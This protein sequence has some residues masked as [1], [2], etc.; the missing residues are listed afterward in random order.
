[1]RRGRRRLPRSEIPNSPAGDAGKGRRLRPGPGK[2]AR[3]G[4]GADRPGEALSEPPQTRKFRYL[5]PLFT[6]ILVGTSYIPFPPWALYFCLVPLWVFWLGEPSRKRIFLGGWVSQFVFTLIGFHWVAHTAHEF[7]HFSWPAAALT[8]LLYCS[9]GHLFLPLSGLVWSLLRD[10]GNLPPWAQ[11]GLLPAVTA[12]LWHYSPMLFP[13][14]LGYPWLWGRFPAFQLAEYAGFSGLSALTV[15]LN[16]AFLVAWESRKTKAGA[17]VLG[18]AL[19]FLVAVN[20][21]G[22]LVG[23]NLPPPD[24]TAR[25]LIVQANIG[26]LAKERAERGREY[27]EEILR[28]YIALTGKGWVPSAGGRPDFALWPE[29]AYPG[30]FLPGEMDSGNALALRTFLRRAGIPLATGA[31]G[32]DEETGKQTNSFFLFEGNGAIAASPYHKTVLL[33][34]GEYMPGAR[35]FPALRTWFPRTADF[36]RGGGPEVKSFRGMTLGPQICYEGLFPS[37]SRSLADQGAQAFVNVTNDS[38]FG[39]SAEPY[40]HLFMTLAR[41]IEFRRP[42]IRATNTGISAVMP[43][44]GGILGLSP[45]HREWFHTFDVP[46]RKDPSP[47]FYQVYGYRLVPAILLLAPAAILLLAWR[48]RG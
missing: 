16:L 38:W 5:L 41:G 13:W 2:K 39:T 24:A 44:D 35:L 45:L 26:N 19:A 7:G 42:V 36:A 48:R 40:Q 21:I 20:A 8:L 27:R 31:R 9:V 46:Y 3:G 15:F 4:R 18:A 6:G 17:R 47:T 28:N 12:L 34:F 22:W 33:A 14:H 37:F 32:I 10:R 29:S 23:R 11:R 43:A 1:L 30:T 25:V